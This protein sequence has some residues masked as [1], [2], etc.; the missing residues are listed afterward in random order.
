MSDY[1]EDEGGIE[2]DAE[3]DDPGATA[4]ED[5]SV[6]SDSGGEGA[7]EAEYEV[8]DENR[9]LTEDGFDLASHGGGTLESVP[10]FQE[11]HALTEG[12]H[13]GGQGPA[14]ISDGAGRPWSAAVIASSR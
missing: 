8:D 4:A 2:F 10:D 13:S 3:D 7:D 11:E 14:G 12:T 1:D 5:D 9:D 6:S